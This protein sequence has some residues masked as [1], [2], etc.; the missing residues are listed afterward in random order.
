MANP[1]ERRGR[2]LP[3]EV[4]PCTGELERV[5]DDGVI[6]LVDLSRYITGEVANDLLA[7]L[8]EQDGE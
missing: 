3:I 6:G 7:V 4:T 2:L 5:F 8:F 1:V